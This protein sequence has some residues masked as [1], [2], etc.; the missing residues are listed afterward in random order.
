VQRK[1]RTTCLSEFIENDLVD[2]AQRLL[3]SLILPRPV[4]IRFL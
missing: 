2:E 1:R 3:S 4:A